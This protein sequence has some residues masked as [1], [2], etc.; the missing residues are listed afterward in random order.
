MADLG[1]KPSI[2]EEIIC[3]FL[4]TQRGQTSEQ[5]PREF[6][7]LLFYIKLLIIPEFYLS[8]HKFFSKNYI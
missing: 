3:L 4:S 8:L 6:Y 7:N 1:L 2:H 5:E